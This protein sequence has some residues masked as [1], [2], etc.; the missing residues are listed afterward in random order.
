MHMNLSY[1][2][3]AK[4]SITASPEAKFTAMILWVICARML[5]NGAMVFSKNPG[6]IGLCFLHF[7]FL[8]SNFG[9][10]LLR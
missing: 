3:G 7:L 6:A 4:A 10:I 1:L 8:P 2:K 9:D 5:A